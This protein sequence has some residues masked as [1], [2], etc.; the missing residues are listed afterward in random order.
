MQMIHSLDA[1]YK[2]ISPREKDNRVSEDEPGT[3]ITPWRTFVAIS[4]LAIV[5]IYVLGYTLAYHGHFLGI[6]HNPGDT[7]QYLALA[8]QYADHNPL[9]CIDPFTPEDHSPFL[10]QPYLSAVGLISRITR[11]P[12]HLVYAPLSVLLGVCL[13]GCGWTLCHS[14]LPDPL[15]SFW[16]WMFLAFGS[17][18]NSLRAIL[19]L[20]SNKPLYGQYR[21]GL[22]D[23]GSLLV[24][25]VGN[26]LRSFQYV[27]IFGVWIL[28]VRHLKED[29]GRQLWKPGILLLLAGFSHAYDSAYL[30]LMTAV[31]F[32]LEALAG[33]RKSKGC[34]HRRLE[35]V[36]VLAL[37]S[38]PPII[39]S[40]YVISSHPIGRSFGSVPQT[41]S[42]LI[43]DLWFTQGLLSIGIVFW[44]VQEIFRGRFRSVQSRFFLSGIAAMMIL[45]SLPV[46][47][48]GRLAEPFLYVS[49]LIG[50]Y[51]WFNLLTWLTSLLG[52]TGLQSRMKRNL[53]PCT[54]TILFLLSVPGTL[55]SHAQRFIQIA[56]NPSPT[57]LFHHP[58]QFHRLVWEWLTQLK[59]P[60]I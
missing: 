37:W 41:A 7:S 2:T 3:I 36:C 6:I 19:D 23:S 24:I 58:Q 15:A 44:F 49:Y 26:S 54:F 11:I 35:Q 56:Y 33:F 53:L 17:G 57:R 27:L 8:R 18:A 1:W 30:I 16:A 29:R 40:L 21:Q 28:L 46:N 59:L 20:F 42:A 9:V 38:L 31:W 39:Y 12:C 55:Y 52:Q 34:F 32:A 10:V 14:M 13:L 25:L 5:P 51:G 4:V 22:F 60:G 43:P 48:S 47:Y 50:A 45:R